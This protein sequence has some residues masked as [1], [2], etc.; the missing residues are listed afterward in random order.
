MRPTL[1]ALT[2][3]RFVAALFVVIFHY[4]RKLDI[5]PES[6]AQFGYEPVTFFFVLSGFVLA[7]SHAKADQLNVTARQFWLR[8]VKRL[9]P[10]YLLALAISAPFLVATTIRTGFNPG[11]LL[12]PLFLQAWW[13]PASLLWNGPAWSLSNEAFFYLLFPICWGWL[14]QPRPSKLMAISVSLLAISTFIKWLTSSVSHD[15]SA[16]F[17]LLN[18]PQFLLGIALARIF[19]SIDERVNFLWL[20]TLALIVVI[21]AKSYLPFVANDFIL[22]TVF[23]ALIWG[24]ADVRTGPLSS[25]WFET[26]GSSSYALYILH[27]PIWL[28]WDRITRVLLNLPLS[29]AVDF[30]GY[31]L[32]SIVA[33]LLSYRFFERRAL[34][35]P[36]R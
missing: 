1:P 7:Y 26:L 11:N 8:R 13:P 24:L 9:V 16:Y 19:L 5:F 29:T 15:F 28:W 23:A 36:H 22:G 31:L 17:P 35:V 10:T 4:D 34:A 33:S 3:A 12:V 6:M 18:A 25:K 21:A 2:S 32:V 20:P 27:V 30:A 14:S